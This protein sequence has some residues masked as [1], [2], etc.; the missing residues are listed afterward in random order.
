MRL[1]RVVA[2]ALAL[3]GCKG[4]E[5]APMSDG[6][7]LYL[8]KC[9]SCHAEYE[10]AKFSPQVWVANVDKMEELKKVHLSPEERAQI[11][12]YLTGDP[13]GRPMAATGR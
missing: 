7:R 13:G 6:R 8:A 1:S 12:Q 11:L 5:R 10:P 3:A 9:T 4:L 2:V